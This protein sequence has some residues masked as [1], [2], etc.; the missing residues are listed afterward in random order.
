MIFYGACALF[1]KQ[2]GSTD[3]FKGL[4]GGR[5]ENFCDYF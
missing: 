3:F 1:S 2:M 5:G 4:N